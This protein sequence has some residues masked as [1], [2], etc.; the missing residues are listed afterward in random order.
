M[1]AGQGVTRIAVISDTHLRQPDQGLISA[2]EDA[3][4]GC[5]MLLHAGDITAMSFL[6]A[7]PFDNVVAV[8]GNMDEADVMTGLPETV[9]LEVAGKR[10]GMIHGWGAPFGLM[11]KVRQRFDNVDVIVFGHSHTA[12]N[13]IMEKVL[14]F[15][16]GAARGRVFGGG[17][18]GILSVGPRTVEGR[19]IKL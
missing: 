15:N 16:P 4:R 5:D 19:I 10:I 14:M 6:K 2:I 3:A 7:L 12:A 9:T 18:M 17:T 1:S 13:D 11:R 8:R